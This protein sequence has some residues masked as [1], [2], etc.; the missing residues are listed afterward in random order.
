MIQ[1]KK[2]LSIFMAAVFV[3]AGLLGNIT[4]NAAALAIPTINFVGLDHT[5]LVAGDKEALTVTAVNYVGNVQYAAYIKVANVWTKLSGYGVPVDSK[6]PYVL[7]KTKALLAGKYP[8]TVYVRK[9]NVVGA[10]SSVFA[11]YDTTYSL[12]L[13]CV[14]KN[15][16][17]IY[18]AGN[19]ECPVEGLKLNFN[20]IDNIGGKVGPYLYQLFSMN[21][22]TGVWSTVSSDYS[23]SPSYTFAAAGNY[24][25]VAHVKTATSTKAYE[26]VKVFN[27][28]VKDDVPATVG[29]TSVILNKTTDALKVGATDTLVATVNP[30]AATNKAVTYKSSDATVASVDATGKVTALKAGIATITVT[31]VDGSK[32]AICAVTVTTPVVVVPVTGVTLNKTT[33]DLTVA[34]TESLVATVNPTTAT[35][36]AVT[37]ASSDVTVATVDATGKV[38]AVKA[39]TATITVTTTDA[40]KTATYVVTVKAAGTV[41]NVFTTTVLHATF[42]ATVNLTLSADGVT[43]FPTATQYQIFDGVKPLSNPTVVGTS[44]TVWPEK[45]AGDLVTVK[46]TN[47]AGTV[48]ATIDAKLGATGTI[49]VAPPVEVVINATVKAATFGANLT[50]TSPLVGA[51]QYQ[52]FD[53]TTAITAIT[54]LGKVRTI[55]PVKAAGDIVTVKLLDATGTVVATKLVT[56]VAGL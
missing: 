33:G 8:V 11:D 53:G 7:P 36:K 9:A 16:S 31:T 1:I 49:V 26:A 38:T 30:A 35:N 15:T 37:Y 25:V 17:S 46:L 52:V 54:D 4:A 47:A 40:S 5:P 28:T 18:V 14:A 34:G 55:F 45:I 41:V 42:G 22:A 29:V 43:N 10:K 48:V 12:A 3:M 39:G 27:V 32:I 20:G 2:T 44:T 24:I 19:A 51:T 50:V 21:T 56:L 13:N 23:A 6:T